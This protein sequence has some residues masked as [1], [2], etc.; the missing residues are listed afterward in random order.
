MCLHVF[1]VFSSL[2]FCF[3]GLVCIINLESSHALLFLQIFLTFHS[4]F[5]DIPNYMYITTLILFHSSWTFS[6]VPFHFIPSYAFFLLF[7]AL[8]CSI[9]SFYLLIFKLSDS[10]LSCVQCTDGTHQRQSSFPILFFT[11]SISFFSSLIVL[12]FLLTFHLVLHIIYFSLES[13][14]HISHCYLKFPEIIST[15]FLY[16]TL[17]LILVLSHQMVFILAF[18]NALWI[19]LRPDILSK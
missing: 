14:D 15:C 13:F 16:F 5:S 19:L 9:R 6:F 4:F 12:I 10:F 18:W 17:V 1:W 7:F 8:H 3:Y 11:S 2:N